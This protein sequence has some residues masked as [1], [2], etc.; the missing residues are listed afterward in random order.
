MA[1]P[2]QSVEYQPAL[3]EQRRSIP[4]SGDS[5]APSPGTYGYDASY[6][7]DRNYAQATSGCVSFVV[8][9]SPLAKIGSPA[10]GG[11]YAVGELVRTTFSCSDPEGPGVASCVDSGGATGGGGIWTP[12]G[13]APTPIR[14]R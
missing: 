5:T 10:S 4:V 9:G 3:A 1:A 6:S 11:V 7:G 2:G 12:P 13:R 14:W 8:Y